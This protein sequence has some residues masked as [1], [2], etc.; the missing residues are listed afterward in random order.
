MSAVAAASADSALCNSFGSPVASDGR[1]WSQLA[2]A[3]GGHR[4]NSFGG[5]NGNSPLGLGNHCAQNALTPTGNGNGV[6]TPY[7]NNGPYGGGGGSGTN[8]SPPTATSADGSP[9]NG[10]T[11]SST[12]GTT[13]GLASACSPNG[14]G[15]GGGG[16]GGNGWLCAA[17]D[18]VN[19][20][21]AWRGTSIATLRRKALEHSSVMTIR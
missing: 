12:G 21:A 5:Q 13:G 10:G 1:S 16:G 15:V 18:A 14:T 20:A 6:Q 8:C 19:S 4:P 3:G 9:P 2:V 11:G 7:H 17:S